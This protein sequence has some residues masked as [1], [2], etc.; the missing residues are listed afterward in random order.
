MSIDTAL[1]RRAVTCKGWRYEPGMRVLFSPYE[2]GIPQGASWR[3]ILAVVPWT[4]EEVCN[5][6]EMAAA[7]SGGLLD[8]LMPRPVTA[9]FDGRPGGAK[10]LH[11]TND[12]VEWE[13]D[14][15]GCRWPV[16]SALGA[17]GCLPD[18]SDPATLGCLLA[19]V[20]EAWVDP[21][22]GLYPVRMDDCAPWWNVANV[23]GTYAATGRTEA[24]AL[25]AA[26]EAA[27]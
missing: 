11:V 6:H 26:L 14:D 24:A 23:W 18:L 3:R 5:G 13:D 21:L 20:R 9:W 27:P 22:L 25:V 1:A 12:P 16:L 10:S 15:D 8:D 4:D 17:A 7:I 19:L 2:I